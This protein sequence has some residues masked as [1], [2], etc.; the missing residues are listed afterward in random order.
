VP[1]G[2]VA[3]IRAI[4]AVEAKRKSAKGDARIGFD[5]V[6]AALQAPLRQIVENGGV[7]GHVVVEKVLGQK[8]NQ[9]YNA[10][11]GEYVNLVKAGIIDPALVGRTALQNG[12]SVAGLM[13]T[14]NVLVTDLND[15]EDATAGAVS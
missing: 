9:G 15:G 5:I 10:A 1:G 2:G 11:T 13:L 12:A 7:D 8:G 6:A 3:Y 4:E 14:T